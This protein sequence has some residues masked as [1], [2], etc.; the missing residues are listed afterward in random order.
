MAL[1]ELALAGGAVYAGIQTYRQRSQKRRL[2]D[3]LKT[4]RAE[5][6]ATLQSALAKLDARYQLFV[7]TKID[8]LLGGE[9]R[10]RQMDL[11]TSDT[12]L[13]VN[14]SFLTDDAEI[15]RYLALSV[16][17]VGLA[18]AAN[19][20]FPPL[21]IL[22]TAGA[23]VMTLPI[24][25]AAYHSIR[26][27][28][29]VKT[30]LIAA[31]Y[32][33]G[34]W[35]N[36]YFVFGAL[37]CSL[38][39]VSMKVVFQVEGRSRRSI[40]NIFGQ[41]PRFAW[42][43]VD[44]VE[45][46]TAVAELQAGDLI[47]VNAGEPIP[48]DGVICH[49][50]ASVDQHMLTGEAQP[51]EK[52]VGDRVFAA[53]LMLTGRAQ[54][55]VEKAGAETTAAQIGEILTQTAAYQ[56]EVE[57]KGKIL[58]DKSVL[59]NLLLSLLALPLRGFVGATAVLGAGF[60]FNLRTC[61]LLGILNYLQIAAR[62]TILIKDGRALERLHQVDTF[63]FDKTGTLTLEQPSVAQLHCCQAD[64]SEDAL[65]IYAAA[66]EYRQPHPIA[67]AILAAAE[68]RGLPLPQIDAASYA[69]GYGIQVTI[70]QQVIRVG[71]DRF[72]QL[73]AIAIPEAIQA[74]QTTCRQ[75][76]RALVMVARDDQLIGALE[77]HATLRPEVE[78][79]LADLRQRGLALAILSGDQEGP[80]RD[81]AHA[82]GIESYFANILPENKATIIEQLQSEGH[83][84]CF[85]GDGINDAIALKKAD[86]SISLRGASTIATDTA[87]IVLMDQ[88][89]S[90]LGNL[91][92]L[93]KNFDKTI[94]QSFWTT[95]I[96]GVICIG[97]VFFLHFGIVAA[98]LLFQLGFF[99][100]LGTAM[101]PL[102][103]EQRQNP[104]Q[105]VPMLQSVSAISTI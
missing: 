55:Q 63:V 34:M 73:E 44:G 8:P 77:L 81:L 97:G 74:L 37:V 103:K 72:M 76:G 47:V 51:A 48:V 31:L 54:I 85:I 92:D 101:L 69:V 86:V 99:T 87:Q 18:T 49:G 67:K 88:S 24:Y 83:V 93:A 82:L 91:L 23:L 36:G 12:Q 21:L 90:K 46:Q 75:K 58:A 28:K 25:Q 78:T 6:T 66:A 16:G 2:A 38:F 96:P 3:I 10:Q 9:D 62:D 59:P 71:S 40:T 19:L 5:Q 80:T 68:A 53:T 29:R 32:L 52:G 70:D 98:E 41:Q 27:Y 30:D 4:K 45:V 26:Q 7:Q 42:L 94:Q 105:E 14:D 79:V 1:L 56:T 57:S 64:I 17:I 43:I 11:L 39:F 60:G 50:I 84:V 15:N 33:S 104:D 61:S 22:T 89:L 65:L 35:L 102:L 100:G 95:M 20:I 13:Q